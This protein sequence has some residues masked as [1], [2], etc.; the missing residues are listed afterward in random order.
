MFRNKIIRIII[1]IL[2]CLTFSFTLCSCSSEPLSPEDEYQLWIE[3]QFGW[4]GAHKTLEELI[5]DNLNDE[6]SYEHIETSYI[7]IT[8]DTI[9]KEIN[10]A[11]E[12]DG[13][14]NRVEINDLV[15]MI[16]FSADNVF[17]GTVK[18]IAVG[19]SSYSENTI[20]LITIE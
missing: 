3:D 9:K 12:A 10:E 7:E 4:D 16:E 11:L 14:E 2:I 17:G 1:T 13:Y 19:I 8:D 5:I 15:V 20:T 6:D 18:S